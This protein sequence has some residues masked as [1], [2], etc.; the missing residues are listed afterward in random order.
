[1]MPVLRSTQTW[2]IGH[3]LWPGVCGIPGNE[4]LLPNPARYKH[5]N[6]NAIK[7]YIRDDGE[8]PTRRIRAE[9]NL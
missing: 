5:A 9:C 4:I 2:A 6:C 7:I 8:A 3:R 1:M